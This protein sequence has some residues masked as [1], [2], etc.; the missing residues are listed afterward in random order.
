[1]AK[2]KGLPEMKGKLIRF[3]RLYPIMFGDELEHELKE[4]ELPES[5]RKIPKDTHAA[6]ESGR[7]TGP[8]VVRG[9]IRAGIVYAS[10]GETNPKSGQPVSDY[11]I[12]LHE[13]PDALHPNG[14]YKF[15]EKTMRE[16]ERTLGARL[17]R[18]AGVEKVQ[19]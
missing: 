14:E 17:A 4:V 2:L 7:V 13:D 18:R 3:A 5:N 9:K 15:L 19:L 10:Q 8:E 16:S 1:M 6:E 12:P 11:I